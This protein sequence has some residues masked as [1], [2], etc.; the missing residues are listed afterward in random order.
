MMQRDIL[1]IE[2]DLLL[3]GVQQRYGFDFHNYARA[4]LLRRLEKFRQDE[5]LASLSALQA[6]VLHDTQAMSRLLDTISINV[7]TMFRDP[8]FYRSLRQHVLPRLATYPYLRFWVAGCANGEEAVSLAILLQEAKLLDRTRIYCTDFSTQNVDRAQRGI[9]SLKKVKEF[10]SNYQKSGGTG[11]FSRYYTALYDQAKFSDG[12]L[13]NMSFAQHNLATDQ[14]FNEFH[15]VCCRNVMI[16]FDQTLQERVMHLLRGSMAPR[17]YLGLGTKE[18]IF[19]SR[20]RS[21]FTEIG[22][23]TRLFQL[24]D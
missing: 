23:A 5:G 13:G 3:A 16:Y 2:T 8:D 7:S 10:T 12:L 19:P 9:F 15:V 22:S 14:S 6:L 17:G 18:A 11:D 20:L 21:H 24:N 1:Q 4:S